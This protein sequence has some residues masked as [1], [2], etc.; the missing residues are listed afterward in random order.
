MSD[1]LVE[2]QGDVLEIDYYIS[3]YLFV[4]AEKR[5]VVIFFLAFGIAFAL[6][7][8]LF[9]NPEYASQATILVEEPRS[10]ITSR[11]NE[12]IGPQKADNTYVVAEGEKLKSEA[13]AQEIIKILPEDIKEDLK[14]HMDFKSQIKEGITSL[15]KAIIGK[16][17]FNFFKK[18][19]YDTPDTADK[20]LIDRPLLEELNNRVTIKTRSARAM[21]WITASSFDKNIAPAIVKSYIDVWL[22][23][24]LAENKKGIRGEREFADEQSK[25]AFYNYKKVEGELLEFKKKYEI[26]PSVHLTSDVEI[27]LEMERLQTKLNSAKERYEF[28]DK[29][30]LE[31]RRK[32]SGVMVNIRL[33]NPP[34]IPI[35]PL[36]GVRNK[37]MFFGVAIGFVLGVMV[38]LLLDLVEG[39]IRHENDIIKIVNLPIL[40]SLPKI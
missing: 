30:Y 19:V 35:Y 29:I 22:A 24:N 3:K 15:I 13:F 11:I 17:L 14:Y 40:G 2:K 5:K 10:S 33:I 26:P 36:K 8:S 7:V 18:I 25:V 4:I 12:K 34:R 20:S 28:I 23:Q 39:P 31:T 27:Q 21:V 32:E 37:L 6:I 16:T 9:V 1:L 38:A